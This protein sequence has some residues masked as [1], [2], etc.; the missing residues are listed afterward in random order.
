MNSSLESESTANKSE[1]KTEMFNGNR[2]ASR[3]LWASNPFEGRAIV[4][5]RSI[6]IV[7]DVKEEE[8][9]EGLVML[10]CYCRVWPW[11]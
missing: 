11:Q 10:R 9:E 7:L 6:V 2:T 5:F 8:E 1:Q 3:L 4:T